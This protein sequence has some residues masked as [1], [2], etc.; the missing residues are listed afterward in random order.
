VSQFVEECP[1]CGSMHIGVHMS[2]C[3]RI[4]AAVAQMPVPQPTAYDRAQAEL[5]QH[6][7]SLAQMVTS[8][9]LRLE[10][11]LRRIEALELEVAKL[12]GPATTTWIKWCKACGGAHRASESCRPRSSPATAYPPLSDEGT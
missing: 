11:S 2:N 12:Q 8:L 9:T 5:N 1:D 3:P 10:A 6:L 7:G 4:A